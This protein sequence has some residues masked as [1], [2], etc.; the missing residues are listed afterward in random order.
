M[1]FTIH[2]AD[3]SS[4]PGMHPNLAGD[5]EPSGVVQLRKA[6]AES[7]KTSGGNARS[8]PPGH[9]ASNEKKTNVKAPVKSDVK[10]NKAEVEG[11]PPYSKESLSGDGWTR[12]SAKA[13]EMFQAAK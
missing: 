1:A 6:A 11:T 7:L 9:A 2:I 12:A 10:G 13:K 8:N 3:S 5:R 4:V